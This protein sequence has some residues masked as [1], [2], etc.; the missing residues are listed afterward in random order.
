MKIFGIIAAIILLLIIGSIVGGKGFGIGDESGDVIQYKD[1]ISEL[2]TTEEDNDC[3]IIKVEETTIWIGEEECQD[4][5]TL[6]NK[7]IEYHSSGI[8]EYVVENNFAIKATYDD[9]KAILSE[10]EDTLGIKVIYN[11]DND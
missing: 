4:I 6:E 2:D 1:A 10:L 7:I 5:D 9:V 11:E 8:E 3:I